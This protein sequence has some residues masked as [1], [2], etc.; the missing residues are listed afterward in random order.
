MNLP[1][2][3]KSG[4]YKNES[5]EYFLTNKSGHEEDFVFYSSSL[6]SKWGFNDGDT[7]SEESLET[8]INQFILPNLDQKVEICHISTSH[9]PWRAE[10]ID[11]V[12]VHQYWSDYEKCPVK[13]TPEFLFFKQ[14]DIWKALIEKRDKI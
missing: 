8:I 4:D 9:N 10:S 11:G 6:L 14:K 13:I 5:Y 2:I 12:E 1:E 3:M 7:W